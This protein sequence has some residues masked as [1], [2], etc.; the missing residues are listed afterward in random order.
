MISKTIRPLFHLLKQ[1]TVAPRM[2][3]SFSSNNAMET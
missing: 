2:A 3:F 1:Q